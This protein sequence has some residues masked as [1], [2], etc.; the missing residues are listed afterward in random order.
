MMLTA[1][2]PLGRGHVQRSPEIAAIAGKYGKSPAQVALRWLLDQEGVAAIPKAA[3]RA[4][5]AAN[6]DIFDFTLAPEDRASID[7]LGGDLRVVDPGWGPE[8]DPP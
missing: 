6:I 3:S 4:H 5:A 8:W 2:T 1:Y 7:A